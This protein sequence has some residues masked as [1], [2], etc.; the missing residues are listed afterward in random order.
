MLSYSY[1]WCERGGG[2]CLLKKQPASAT[3]PLL[4]SALH[5]AV[6][7][8]GDSVVS[9]HGVALDLMSAGKDLPFGLIR[10]GWGGREIEVRVVVEGATRST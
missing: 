9:T 2:L 6:S 10:G 8:P 1:K 7:R 3:R 4:P 5:Q